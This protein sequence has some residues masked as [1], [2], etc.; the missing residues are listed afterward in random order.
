MTV[1]EE[2]SRPHRLIVFPSE[3]T[4]DFWRRRLASDASVRAID[5]DR[6]I[7]WDAFKER[8][9]SVQRMERPAASIHRTLFTRA[10]LVRNGTKPFLSRLVDREVAD[11]SLHFVRIVAEGLP[12]LPGLL[13]SSSTMEIAPALRADFRLLYDEYRTF[14]KRNNLFE[15]S[16][17]EVGFSESNSGMPKTTLFFPELIEDFGEYKNALAGFVDCV[18][19]DGLGVDSSDTVTVYR[20][21]WSELEGTFQ[22]IDT[23]LRR[24]VLPGDIV[25]THADLEGQRDAIRVTARRYSIPLRIQSGRMILEAPG[26]SFLKRLDEVVRSEFSIVALS[27]L[28]MDRSVP[29]VNREETARLVDYGYRCHLY[30]HEEWKR[31]NRRAGKDE[32]SLGGLFERL[33]RSLQRITGA[34]SLENLE[35]ALRTF[36]AEFFD[37]RQWHPAAERV[38]E[39][40]LVHLAELRRDFNGLVDSDR[41]YDELNTSPWALFLSVLSSVK[42]VPRSPAGAVTVYGY[43]V[44]A[45]IEPDHHFILGF[46]QDAT[47]VSERQPFGITIDSDSGRTRPFIH[48]YLQSGR[49]V[50]PSCSLRSPRGA[51]VPVAGYETRTAE[52]GTSTGWWRNPGAP[53]PER[54]YEGEV[55]GLRRYFLIPETGGGTA[56]ESFTQLPSFRDHPVSPGVAAQLPGIDHLS[57][58]AMEAYLSCPFAYLLTHR[59]GIRRENRGKRGLD[60]F[61]QGSLYHAVF[62]RVDTSVDPPDIR[63]VVEEEIDRPSVWRAIPR[64]YIAAFT[65]RVVSD[66][67]AVNRRLLELLDSPISVSRELTLSIPVGSTILE[68]RIDAVF[69]LGGSL[70]IV[71][72]KTGTSPTKGEIWDAFFY[73]GE[74]TLSR[75]IQLP[76]YTILAEKH[77]NKEVTHLYYGLPRNSRSTCVKDVLRSRGAPGVEILEEVRSRLPSIVDAVFERMQAGDYTVTTDCRSCH[78]RSICRTRFLVRSERSQVWA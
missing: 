62:Q 1:F 75:S 71:D 57:A 14:L 27:S 50:Y 10:L 40:M 31:V 23:L 49:S 30:S 22:K 34:S 29:W 8:V 35:T 53:P 56:I 5:R 18:S 64:W 12:T 43:R 58:T 20:D 16:W 28:V 4:A 45:G 65:E 15:P 48:V 52:I 76:V 11:R 77:F 66:V 13:R 46:S 25:I 7:S 37:G 73:D 3:V 60:G 72:Y 36:A 68:G 21:H 41:E 44:A 9:L 38:Y 59:L 54:L 2:Y 67:A 51:Q 69:D 78:L 17:E 39:R 74:P 26:A 70:A 47:A 33:Y 6:L 19:A 42:Y 32:R 63:P 24:G 61:V 55:R